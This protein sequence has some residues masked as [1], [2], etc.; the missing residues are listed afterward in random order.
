MQKF[1]DARNEAFKPTNDS[2]VLKINREYCIKMKRKEDEKVND[3]VNRF[4][5]AANLAK[6]HNMDVSIKVK[7]L[8][9]LHNA[10]LADRP[11]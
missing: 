7:G 1:I 9:L 2:R 4:D 10:G 6:R 8:K 11:H 5:M 3:F